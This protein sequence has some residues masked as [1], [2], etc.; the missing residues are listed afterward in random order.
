MT[1]PEQN[2]P[3]IAPKPQQARVAIVSM[4][5]DDWGGS[6]ELWARSL[7]FLR[8]SGIGASLSK[9]GINPHHPR[10][11]ALAQAGVQLQPLGD[12][13]ANAPLSRRLQKKLRERLFRR[14]PGYWEHINFGKHLQ[15]FRPQLV[16]IAQGINFDGLDYAAVCSAHNIPYVVVCQKAVEFFWPPAHL[17]QSMRQAFQRAKKCYFVSQHNLQLTEEQFG[18]RFSNACVIHNPVRLVPKAL[19]FPIASETIRLACIGRLFIIDKGQDIL[20]RILAQPKWRSRPVVVSFIGIGH[21]EAG[22]KELAALLQLTNVVFE[23]QVEGMEAVWQQHHALVLPSRCEGM[24]L[25]VLEALAAGR[26]VIASKAGGTPE[27]VTEGVNG[28]LAE[29]NVEDFEA[30]MERA[31]QQRHRW[32]EMGTTAVA[33]IQDQI[34]GSPEEVFANEITELIYEN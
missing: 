31:W 1:A 22:I 34:T 16:I 14:P 27:Y 32:A 11:A 25:V 8:Q 19:P 15:L 29:A 28:F 30:A 7:P 3:T 21:D 12:T 23:G 2:K 20:L 10:I 17:R 24:P 13:P 26:P 9:V 5:S 4:C 18:F 6:E 33:M